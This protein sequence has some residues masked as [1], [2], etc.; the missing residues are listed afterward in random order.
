MFV[1]A[2]KIV[3]SVA[4]TFPK[5]MVMHMTVSVSNFPP[6]SDLW[7]EVE[8]RHDNGDIDPSSRCVLNSEFQ[9]VCIRAAA[10]AVASTPSVPCDPRL[11][12]QVG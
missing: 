4:G 5:V 6:N 2:C 9:H 1:V 7:C 10:T 8:G 3:S 11:L 12:V